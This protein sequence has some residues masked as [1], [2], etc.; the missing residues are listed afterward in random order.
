MGRPVQ[1]THLLTRTLRADSAG[2]NGCQAPACVALYGD[3]A[4]HMLPSLAVEGACRSV[5]CSGK[6]WLGD[7]GFP[8]HCSRGENQTSRV[9]R[10]TVSEMV[11]WRAYEICIQTIGKFASHTARRHSIGSG[12]FSFNL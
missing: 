10:H 1:C 9:I 12:R 3:A 5:H 7:A 6:P 8:A 4:A 11:T 2:G